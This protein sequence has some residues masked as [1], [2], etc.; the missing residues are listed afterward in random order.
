VVGG[1]G[2]SGGGGYNGGGGFIGGV[3]TRPRRPVVTVGDMENAP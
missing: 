2:Y 1:A 3:D